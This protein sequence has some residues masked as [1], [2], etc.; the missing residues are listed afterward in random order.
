MMPAQRYLR[1]HYSEQTFA[2]QTLAEAGSHVPDTSKWACTM[3]SVLA[4]VRAELEK[5]LEERT[6]ARQHPLLLLTVSVVC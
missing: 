1:G 5:S 4:R 3:V 6:E 2:F